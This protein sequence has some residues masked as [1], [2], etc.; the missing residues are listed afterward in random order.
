MLINSEISLSQRMEF[1]IRLKRAI[2]TAGYEPK[3]TTFARAFNI[4]ANGASVTIHGARKWLIGEAYPTQERLLVLARWL[5]VTPEWLR[6][7]MAT[8]NSSTATS[9]AYRVLPKEISML[10]DFRHLDEKSQAVI[11]DLISSLLKHRARPVL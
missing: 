4:H 2:V 3:P 9:E 7:G 8:S 11:R 5:G 10:N 6:Y 1:S